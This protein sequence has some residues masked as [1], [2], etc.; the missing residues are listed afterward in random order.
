MFLLRLFFISLLTL[1][2][3]VA[4]GD[5]LQQAIEHFQALSS[6]SAVMRSY[7]EAEHTIRY[8]YKKPGYVR[9]DF[10]QPHRGAALV[11]RPDSGKVQLR[12]FGFSKSLVLTMKPSARLVRGPSGHRADE[13]DIG[14]LLEHAQ[15]LSQSGNQRVLREE[16]QQDS[17]LVVLEIV[18]AENVLVDGVQRYLLWLDKQLKLPRRVESF[19]TENQLIE[20]LFLDDLALNVD[21][22]DIFEL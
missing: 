13:S 1:S 15:K 5:M 3:A 18:G 2:P 9:M 16:A 20:G 10:I 12:P 4:S 7:G 21:F 17:I 11:Y 8:R 14:V 22:S 19:D 6:Y